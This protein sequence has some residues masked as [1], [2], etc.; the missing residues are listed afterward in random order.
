MS[1]SSALGVLGDNALQKSSYLLTCIT[2]LP[3]DVDSGN[4]VGGLRPSGPVVVEVQRTVALRAHRAAVQTVVCS[5][6]PPHSTAST[7]ECH[8]M[9]TSMLTSMSMSMSINV[10]RIAELHRV[11]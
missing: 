4:V 10:A 11:S 3:A 7:S 6:Q 5:T 1:A 2:N 9:L 8:A